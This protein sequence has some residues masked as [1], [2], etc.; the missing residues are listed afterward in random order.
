MA[1]ITARC[2]CTIASKKGQHVLDHYTNLELG[3]RSEGI[4]STR[5]ICLVSTSEVK[6]G[7]K[8]QF[9]HEILKGL[10]L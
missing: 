5:K 2:Y 4:E 6:A 1:W 3:K 7:K 9:D 10:T 8:K